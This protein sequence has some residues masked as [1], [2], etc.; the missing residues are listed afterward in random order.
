VWLATVDRPRPE[1][2]RL[3]RLLTSDELV[4]CARYH[5][6]I[7]R[8][9]FVARRAIRR[10]ILAGC[11]RR[12]PGEI[13]FEIGEH[14]KPSVAGANPDDLRFNESES[15]GQ[16]L[17]AVAWSHEVGVDIERLAVEPDVVEILTRFGDA[18]ERESYERLSPA[19]R[20]VAFYR[21]WTA[22]EAWMKAVGRGLYA[23]LDSVSIEFPEM[24][25]WRLEVG[26]EAEGRW[27]LRHL[28]APT[29]FVASVVVEGGLRDI[30]QYRWTFEPEA[31]RAVR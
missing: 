28:T 17:L 11:L 10:L 12:S 3:R 24:D 1:H 26:V 14:G 23:P 25:E 13:E 6:A 9:R 2:E 22:K 16:S 7:D 15:G 4:L 31:G 18:R 30:C 29:G 19:L 21:W 27:T 20:P 5:R 8:D